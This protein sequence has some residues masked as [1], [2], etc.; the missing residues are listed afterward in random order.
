MRSSAGLRQPF[1][2]VLTTL[3]KLNLRR[4][5]VEV[6]FSSKQKAFLTVL[7]AHSNGISRDRLAGI[8]WDNRPPRNARHSLSQAIHTI[9]TSLP[10]LEIVAD[11]ETVKLTG[12][13][14]WD[15]DVLLKACA[16]GQAHKAIRAY[17]GEFL[18][19]LPEISHEFEDWRSS[20]QTK[21]VNAVQSAAAAE[22]NDLCI[23]GDFNEAHKILNA[24]STRFGDICE[25]VIPPTVRNTINIVVT[26]SASEQLPFAGRTAEL[27]ALHREL[28]TST[29]GLTI[30][31]VT[32][33]PGIGKSALCSRFVRGAVAQGAAVMHCRA[34]PADRNV[35][36]RS[37]L[38]ALYSLPEARDHI[39]LVG[40]PWQAVIQALSDPKSS[41]KTQAGTDVQKQ[42]F[43]FEAFTRVM[44]RVAEGR[45]LILWIDDVQ[46]ADPS[47]I[48][49]LLYLNTRR[50]KLKSCVVL[51][52]RDTDARDSEVNS[53]LES[54]DTRI[55]VNRLSRSEVAALVKRMTRNKRQEIGRELW[56]ITGGHPYLITEILRSVPLKSD[57]LSAKSIRD[58]ASNSISQLIATKIES[59][60]ARPKALLNALAVFDKP[61]SISLIRKVVALRRADFMIALHDLLERNLIRDTNG[62]LSCAHDLIRE[63][64]YLRL[65]TTQKQLLHHFC[66]NALEKSAATPR[67]VIDHLLMAK[68]R[69]RAYIGALRAAAESRK[70]RAYKETDYCLS[71]VS[72]ATR[73]EQKK[74]AVSWRRALNAFEAGNF[75]A[76]E[77][78]L[79]T[80]DRI[81]D[82]SHNLQARIRELRLRIGRLSGRVKPAALMSESRALAAVTN[83]KDL[84][85]IHCQALRSCLHVIIATGGTTDEATALLAAFIQ[86]ADSYPGTSAELLA[87]CGCTH[88]QIWLGHPDAAEVSMTKAVNSLA[89]C[90]SGFVKNEVFLN[91]GIMKYFNGELQGA[92]ELYLRALHEAD[93]MLSMRKRTVALINLS[94]VYLDLGEY[95][96][97]IGV[98]D[99]IISNSSS[100]S[101]AVPEIALVHANYTLLHLDKGEL[102]PAELHAKE[103]LRLG[104]SIEHSRTMAIPLAVV[105]ICALA[106]GSIAEARKC[107]Q[108]ILDIKEASLFDDVLVIEQFLRRLSEVERDYDGARHRL[109]SRIANGTRYNVCCRAGLNLE[110]ARVYLH[111][112]PKAAFRIA[113]EQLVIASKAGARSLIDE[114]DSIIAR[115]RLK[116][117]A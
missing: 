50:Q 27:Y 72:R 80:L 4:P 30:A 48:S 96:N 23:R 6:K 117:T 98:L 49:F 105:G 41:R 13:I 106:R 59:L 54:A 35:G 60:E 77:R 29:Q 10:E 24:F 87:L 1:E 71:V 70:D 109:E 88:L 26:E 8:L 64:M 52:L 31:A 92:K 79:S 5:D 90:Q 14:L 102:E 66:A 58:V 57:S 76:S 108:A 2:L 25:D 20:I 82:P 94:A 115:A 28:V 103:C 46:W 86:V 81:P 116:L 74:S 83:T 67:E 112:D 56:R 111:I 53:L 68:A 85:D 113:T 19:G 17:S 44:Q 15:V 63:A 73:S 61:V 45:S 78:H 3:G 100:N 93:E 43:V 33:Q 55:H 101:A 38:G 89:T 11:A 36:Y 84:I 104:Q 114:A 91:A 42:E 95:D 37:L 16:S 9:R 22:I 69:K 110:L 40:E 47:T 97:A 39:A 75:D 21:I 18:V 99:E 51:S 62:A 7:V 12:P 34:Y 107:R 65:S 32:G